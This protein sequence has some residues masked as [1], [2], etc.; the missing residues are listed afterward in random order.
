MHRDLYDLEHNDAQTYDDVVWFMMVIVR[1]RL[2]SS[3]QFSAYP[4]KANLL[5][6]CRGL[7]LRRVLLWIVLLV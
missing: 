7:N 6:F 2:D 4:E 5:S 1:K 3:A